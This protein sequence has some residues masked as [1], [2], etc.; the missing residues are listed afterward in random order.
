MATHNF[1]LDPA[2]LHA[3]IRRG[4][5]G[6][7]RV[8]RLDLLREH[9][10]AKQIDRTR[11]RKALFDIAGRR[12]LRNALL[13]LV[14]HAEAIASDHLLEKAT[15][16]TDV[17]KIERDI[18]AGE[19]RGASAERLAHARGRVAVLRHEAAARERLRELGVAAPP[20]PPDV[21][22]FCC[23]ITHCRMINPV[24]AS[25]GKTYE[26]SAIVTHL[27]PRLDAVKLSPLT[28]EPLTRELTPHAELLE[29]INRHYAAAWDAAVAAAA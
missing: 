9:F 26:R 1:S 17:A 2:L 25:D 8:A 14:P 28:R 19:L 22:E 10:L 29:E 16:G 21:H 7:D 11:Y 27:G 18:A 12:G 4:L 6:R 3:E 15:L 23:P 24:I 20:D 5:R 13:A